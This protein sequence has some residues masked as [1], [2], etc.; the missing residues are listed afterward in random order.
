MLRLCQ[1]DNM[2]QRD[3]L[4]GLLL[5]AKRYEDALSFCQI[6]MDPQ[7]NGENRPLGGCTFAPPSPEPLS[8]G[9]I[10]LHARDSRDTT[11][12]LN[13]ALASFHL[14]GDC[15]QARQYLTLGTGGNRRIMSEMWVGSRQ[16]GES[17]IFVATACDILLF[18]NVV[19]D[20][21]KNA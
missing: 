7:F 18:M 17:C 20:M 2:G 14:Y 16:P 5:R 3:F 21:Y 1:G 12:L 11:Q 15:E 4:P 10:T 6:W 9:M 13:T 19:F 8:Q